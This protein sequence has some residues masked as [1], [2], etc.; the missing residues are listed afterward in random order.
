MKYRYCA[1]TVFLAILA[2]N[3]Q[4]QV[5]YIVTDSALIDSIKIMDRGE[6]RNSQ[7]CERLILNKPVFY[8]PDDIQ[9]YGF[10]NGRVYVSREITIDGKQKKVFLERL[11]AGPTSLYYYNDGQI[12]LFV[13]EN[14]Q[15]KLVPVPSG[16]EGQ[17]MKTFRDDLKK[18][19]AGCE[20]VDEAVKLTSSGKKS[21]ALLTERF[22]QCRRKPFPFFRMGAIAGI[23]YSDLN[24]IE[25]V[26]GDFLQQENR[27]FKNAD[28]EY[29][30]GFFFGVFA[31]FPLIPSDFYIHPEVYVTKN[32]YFSQ[33]E[34]EEY[35]VEVEINTAAIN[36]PVLMRYY[37][38]LNK[39]R[40]YL[41]AGLIYAY[42]FKHDF[43]SLTM[44]ED[45][46]EY[47]APV[48]KNQ[49]G[50]STG[51]GCQID[52]TY[53]LRLYF[54]IKYN[55][56]YGIKVSGQESYNKN[57]LQFSAAISF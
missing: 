36:F 13:F 35:Y 11:K 5:S 22:N 7:V 53:R 21:M 10:A 39:V 26:S 3:L 33:Y 27:Y 42:Q 49:V 25:G 57:E 30:T 32:T 2:L 52:L 23:N 40:P 44:P 29:E 17:S 9:E 19:T 4:A 24:Y 6:A 8:Y 46:G 48:V 14:E 56:L 38:P 18:I 28:F 51:L 43:Y 34:L 15:V 31:D 41:N 47:P 37:F 55:Y 12:R 45:E 20:K 54:D 50:P 1:L 16:Y